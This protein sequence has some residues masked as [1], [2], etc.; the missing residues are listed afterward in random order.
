MAL[1]VLDGS[2]ELDLDDQRA[3]EKGRRMPHLVIINKS[4]LPGVADTTMLNGSRRVIVSAKTGDGLE[5][6]RMALRLNLLSRK[7]ELND[8]LILTNVR[9]CEAVTTAAA[10]LSA[11]EDGLKTGLPHEVILLELYR[12]LSGLNELTGEVV[13]EDILDRIF[14]TFCIGK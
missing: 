6:L 1:I 12:G 9:Q 11:A 8:D 14:S 13:T 7:T 5:E 3:L 4:D 10:G 2:R